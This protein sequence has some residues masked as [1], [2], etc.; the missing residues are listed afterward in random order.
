MKTI[1]NTI[2]K[3]HVVVI[4]DSLMLLKFLNVFLSKEY[5][6][7]SYTSTSDALNDLSEGCVSPDCIL[8]DYYLG[9]DLNGLEFIQNLKAVNPTI[10]VLVLSGSVDMTEKIE[11]LQNGAVDFISKPFNPI[12]LDARLKNVLCNSSNVNYYRHAV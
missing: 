4:D 7:T 2:I 10:P 6:V 3:P 9:R 5:E 8:T 12:E 1:G 11:C